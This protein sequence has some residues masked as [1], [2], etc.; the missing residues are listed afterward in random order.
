MEN[1]GLFSSSYMLYGEELV[2]LKANS[3]LLGADLKFPRMSC[4]IGMSSLPL[5]FDHRQTHSVIYNG[6]S[7]TCHITSELWKNWKPKVLC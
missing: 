4:L 3:W 1:L 6:G 5:G 2:L 7:G